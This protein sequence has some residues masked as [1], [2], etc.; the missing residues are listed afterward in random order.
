M[1]AEH[2]VQHMPPTAD[3]I[4]FGSGSNLSPVW[5]AKADPRFCWQIRR[6]LHNFLEVKASEVGKEEAFVGKSAGSR[7]HG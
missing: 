6:S 2:S 7:A 5:K 4:F 1:L 3:M